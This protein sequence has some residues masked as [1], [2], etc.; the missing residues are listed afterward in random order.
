VDVLLLV[1]V[2]DGLS[3]VAQMARVLFLSSAEAALKFGAAAGLPVEDEAIV[4]KA[5]P[6]SVSKPETVLAWSRQEDALVF[7][8]EWTSDDGSRVDEEGVLIPPEA[9][10]QSLITDIR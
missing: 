10:L 5:A 3:H 4:M 9:F 6:I 1:G 7:G 8:R 2:S